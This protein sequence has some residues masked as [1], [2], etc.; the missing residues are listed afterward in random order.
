[1]T[2][3]FGKVPH[4]HFLD[5]PI[6]KA[7]GTPTSG[8]SDLGKRSP[9]GVVL[10]RMVGSLNGTDG[11]FRKESTAALTDYGIGVEARDGHRA[12]GEIM[13]WNDPRGFRSPWANGKI[14]APYGDGQKF[15]NQYGATLVNRDLVSI[16][17]SGNYDTPLDDRSRKSIAHLIAYWGDQYKIPA[18]EFPWIENESRNFTIFHQEFTIGTGKICP[19][20]VVMGEIDSLV[21]MAQAHMRRYQSPEAP[22]QEF[23][24]PGVIPALDGRDARIGGVQFWACQR[25]VTAKEGGRFFA[26]ADEQSGQTRSPARADEQF[27]VQWAVKSARG[28]WWWV[29]TRGS[30]I[31]QDE[32]MVQATF[33][34]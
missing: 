28:E 5:R 10:H 27:T 18:D 7:G 16:E 14:S 29:T 11:Y 34:N 15:L 8:W 6:T 31:R 17:I 21:E 33:E 3:V 26:F 23:A 24:K 9:K 12:A 2:I 32:T 25:V 30:R 20:P 22:V 13:R 19:G 1:M 4:P